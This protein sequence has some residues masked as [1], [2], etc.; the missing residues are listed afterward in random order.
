MLPGLVPAAPRER[1]VC[2]HACPP[3]PAPAPRRRGSALTRRSAT[4]AVRPRRAERGAAGPSLSAG[5]EPAGRYELQG[6]PG[7]L[8]RLPGAGA[9]TRRVGT[10]GLCR[11]PTGV[12]YPAATASPKESGSRPLPTAPAAGNSPA[13]VPRILSETR[14]CSRRFPMPPWNYCSQR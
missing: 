3:F 5:A 7:G 11:K 13:V 6:G 8:Q 12:G 10:A 14:R 1:P 2:S 9:P 4:G